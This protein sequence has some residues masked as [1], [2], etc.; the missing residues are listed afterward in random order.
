[1]WLTVPE[2]GAGGAEDPD[3]VAGLP[4][5]PADPCPTGFAPNDIR[6]VASNQ[7]LDAEPVIAVFLSHI[8][9]PLVD[10]EEQN[11]ALIRGRDIEQDIAEQAAGWIGNDRT[12]VGHLDQ[13]RNSSSSERQW[14][15]TDS[16]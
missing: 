11:A 5:C 7:I 1:M 4:G 8:K 15:G 16:N 2:A 13:C 12:E 9:I 10:I 6:I 14:F 3:P